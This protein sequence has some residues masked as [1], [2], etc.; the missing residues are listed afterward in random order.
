[1]GIFKK[2]EQEKK[3]TTASGKHY[4]T[5]KEIRAISKSNLK[6]LWVRISQYQPIFQ[7]TP[8]RIIILLRKGSPAAFARGVP[9]CSAGSDAVIAFDIPPRRRCKSSL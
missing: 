2:N 3:P 7:K 4:L 6:T 5:G 9:R 8:N 1:M